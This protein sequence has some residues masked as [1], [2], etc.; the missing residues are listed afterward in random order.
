VLTVGCVAT[1]GAGR[2]EQMR[3]EPASLSMRAHICRKEP[4]V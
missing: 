1:S 2:S 3:R 4:N